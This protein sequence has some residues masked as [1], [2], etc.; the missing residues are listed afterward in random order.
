VLLNG[1]KDIADYLH[2][3]VRTV[4]RW[5]QL[6]LP[7]IRLRPGRRGSVIAHSESVDSWIESRATGIK[8]PLRPDIA[9]TLQK[10]KAIREAMMD[11]LRILVEEELVAGLTFA[12]DAS[13]S[14][15]PEFRT[16][17]TVLARHA[18]DAIMRLSRRPMAGGLKRE[19]FAAKLNELRAALRKL[20]EE[21]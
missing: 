11:Q 8:H 5:E 10:N 19:G 9:A 12:K 2:C 21:V 6:G 1:W 17:R 13:G 16:R 4:Q 18:Y 15:D 20:G 7:V 14:G 3:G